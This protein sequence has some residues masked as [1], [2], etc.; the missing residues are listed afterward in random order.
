MTE[1]HNG[2]NAVRHG[3]GS[4]ELDLYIGKTV[5]HDVHF[6]LHHG[7]V[8]MGRQLAIIGSMSMV[9]PDGTAKPTASD[10]IGTEFEFGSNVYRY[11]GY[12]NMGSG[13]L[14]VCEL[15]KELWT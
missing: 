5:G 9:R 7:S 8:L 10:A 14:P 11:L 15:V 3:D 12:K 13:Y 4:L 1:Q 2:G 6:Q